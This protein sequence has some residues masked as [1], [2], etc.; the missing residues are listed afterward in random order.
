MQTRYASWIDGL[1]GD[2]LISSPAVLRCADPALV[3]ARRR[4]RADLGSAAGAIRRSLPIDPST[5]VPLGYDEVAARPARRLS[6][7][8][9]HLWTPGPRRRS[10]RRSPAAGE[11][12]E[13]LYAKTSRWTCGRRAHDIIRTWLFS[14][15]VRAHF[16][17]T[18]CRGR[19][20][21]SAAGSSTP[22]A[23]RCR[24][25][26]ATSSF[27]PNCSSSTAPTQ[28]ATGHRRVDPEL[29]PRST[30]AR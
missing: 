18:R 29:T 11:T 21:L 20:A 14:T 17:P 23:R 27:R 22:I 5:D 25:R 4:W 19:T 30:K 8:A 26:R 15:V 24:S 16:E 9:R 10:H 7:R 1:N 6:R 2:W 12:D 13:D 3:S 28:S